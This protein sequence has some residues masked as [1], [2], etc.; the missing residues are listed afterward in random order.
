M[1]LTR[2]LSLLAG[3]LCG[4]ALLTVVPSGCRKSEVGPSSVG[5]RRII[6]LTNGDDPFWDAMR[7]GMKQAAEDL[8]LSA[9]NLEAVLD[10]GDFSEEAQ[11][12]KLN[13]YATQSDIAAVAISSVDAKNRG[14]SE[15]MK[16]LRA[17]GIHVVTIDSDMEDPETRFAYLGTNN[18][19]GGQELGK[20]AKGIKPQGG[21]YAT[22]VGL[23]TVANAIERISGFA[24]GAGTMFQEADSLADQGDENQA[25]E[26][27][28]A[29]LNNH[30]QLD[31]LVGIWAYNAHAIVKVV[32][33]RQLREKV[34]VVVF[35][36]A[37]AALDDMEQGWIDAMIVQN[38][39]QMG[40]LGT[41]L[42]KALID[43]EGEVIK[44]L[45]PGYDPASRRFAEPGD[46]IYTTEL[47]VVVPD[48]GTPLTPDM[49]NA[50][51]KFFK[52]SDFR[53]WMRERNLMGS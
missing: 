31:T 51:T 27:V 35:D 50:D 17:N 26:N 11:I 1:S 34:A 45:Y 24:Q 36:A 25:Q 3:A 19:I 43:E 20:A 6:L 13:Q 15:A 12:N 5:T 42:M 48:Q 41:K 22:F 47:R 32:Q 16:A 44:E 18:V 49:F 30:P 23:K 39:Y 21:T 10:K 2:K 53:A 37:P 52:Y 33:E 46:D 40:Y 29:A 8:N 28:K 4:L 14:I 9:S 38:P 7:E